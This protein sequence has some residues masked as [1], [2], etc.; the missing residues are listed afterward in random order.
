MLYLWLFFGGCACFSHNQQ[1][2]AQ[3]P[4]QTKCV[5]LMEGE[6][7]E[8]VERSLS[9]FFPVWQATG[10]GFADLQKKSKTKTNKNGG[11]KTCER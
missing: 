11:C 10:A 7:A 3:H 1:L 2:S 5:V 6:E 8:E 4:Q 9:H